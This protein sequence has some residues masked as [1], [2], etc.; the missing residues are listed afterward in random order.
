M[1]QHV[2]YRT[3]KFLKDRYFSMVFK[4]R[5]NQYGRTDGIDDKNSVKFH[6]HGGCCDDGDLEK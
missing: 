6:D 4:Q 3:E 1:D 2:H 5:K